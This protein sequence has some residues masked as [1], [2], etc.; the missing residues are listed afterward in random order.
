MKS[1]KLLA[2]LLTVTLV[3]SVMV[4]APALP[5]AVAAKET[6]RISPTDDTFISFESGKE[7]TA[8]GSQTTLELGY[9]QDNPLPLDAGYSGGS[10]RGELMYARDILMKFD[11]QDIEINSVSSAVLKLTLSENG[12]N[13]GSANN[14]ATAA[15]IEVFAADE[16]W[17]ENTV[18]RSSAPD[19]GN[20]AGLSAPLT[21]SNAKT[22]AVA[23]IDLTAYIRQNPQNIYSFRIKTSAS[24]FNFH[25]KESGTASARPVLEIETDGQLVSS[26][27]YSGSVLEDTYVEDS[28]NNRG[29]SFSD[30]GKIVIAAAD[31]TST[32]ALY[33]RNGY[34]KIELPT[35]G[36]STHYDSAKISLHA[37]SIDNDA[38]QTVSL[39]PVSSDW[40]GTDLTWDNRPEADGEA[41]ASAVISK[42][43]R[44]DSDALLLNSYVFDI[45]DYVNANPSVDGIYSFV[46]TSDTNISRFCT[47]EYIKDGATEEENQLYR[48]TVECI[49]REN[50][51]LTLHYT[52]AKFN[53]IAASK[54]FVLPVGNSFNPDD[55]P[56]ALGD[57][58]YFS[59]DLT[60][61][62][63][64]LP[65]T[66]NPGN[67]DVYL[68]YESK[69]I[70]GYEEINVTTVQYEKPVLPD[71]IEVSFSGGSNETFPVTW[72]EIAPENY[73]ASGEFTVMGTLQGIEAEGVSATVKV[74]G[75]TGVIIPTLSTAPGSRPALPETLDVNLDDETTHSMAVEWDEIA[76]E[77]YASVGS[78]VANGTIVLSGMRVQMTILVEEGRTDDRAAIADA[79]TQSTEPNDTHNTGELR[80]SGITGSNSANANSQRKTFLRFDG[81]NFG[82]VYHDPERNADID[83]IVNSTVRLYFNSIANSATVTYKIY[84]IIP[85]NDTWTEDSITWNNSEDVIDGAVYISSVSVK[86]SSFSASWVD[87]DVTSF[88]REHRDDEYLSFYVESD[89]CAAVLVSKDGDDDTLSPTLRTSGYI[90]DA[91]VTLRYMAEIGGK[92]TDIAEP[93]ALKGKLGY[94]YEYQSVIPNPIYY[95]DSDPD[96]IYYYDFVTQPAPP[97]ESES[98]PNL[99]LDSLT[100][101]YNEI[102]AEYT[103]REIT[104][105]ETVTAETFRGTKPELPASVTA[106][107]DNGT[108]VT[109][110]VTWN[111]DEVDF[112]DYSST[113]TFTLY[114]EVEYSDV[115]AEAEITVHE[116]YY[117]EPA[118]Q[119][120]NEFDIEASTAYRLTF[121]LI[122]TD[123][124]SEYLCGVSIVTAEGSVTAYD[125][126][127]EE[128][129]SYLASF[130]EGETVDVFFTSPE[131]GGSM[132]LVLPDCVNY[133]T[134]AKLYPVLGRGGDM[135]LHYMY[136]DE[137][138]YTAPINI[139]F[140]DTFALT[141][142]YF[143]ILNGAYTVT[144]IDSERSD[145]DNL[146]D[147]IVIDTDGLE[148]YLRCS[149][150][151]V[152]TMSTSVENVLDIAH[153]AYTRSTATL[154]NGTDADKTATVIV[155]KYSEDGKLES[156]EHE[157]LTIP[158]NSDSAVI[159]TINVPVTDGYTTILLWDEISGLNPF[160]AKVDSRNPTG[161][162][163]KPETGDLILIPTLSSSVSAS[164]EQTGNE[165]TNM[166]TRDL[167]T[168]W[169]AQAIDNEPVYA[170]IS[171]GG[172][173]DIHTIGLAFYNGS[174]RY[175]RFSVEASEDGSEWTE[176]ISPR[177]SSG[178]TSSV[179]YYTFAPVSARFIRLKGYGWKANV[180]TNEGLV[181][182]SDNWFSVTAF[183]AYGSLNDASGIVYSE[184]I[185]FE[186][187]AGKVLTDAISAGAG[188][189]GAAALN[190]MTYTNYTP[191]TGSALYADITATPDGVGFADGNTALRLYDNVDRNGDSETGAGS[192]G[193]FHK[194]DLSSEQYSIS[195]K[196]YIPN[197]IEGDTYNAQ[198]AGLS[199]SAGQVKG[200]ADTS[201]PVAL[202]LR[203]SP[204]GK[205]KMGF[206]IIRS[207]TYNEGSQENLL[208][209][210][211]PFKSNCVW[212]V[213]L[214]VNAAANTAVITVSDGS[215]TE[216]AF[217]SYGLYNEERTISQTWS[218]SSVN[219]IMF[220]TGAGG[221]CEMYVD[222][223]SVSCNSYNDEEEGTIVYEEDF[224]GFTNGEKIRAEKNGIS[225]ALIKETDQSYTASYGTMLDVDVNRSAMTDGNALHLY[226]Y[227][228]RENDSV[229][230]TGGVFAYIDLPEFSTETVTKIKFDMYAPIYGEYAG[231]ALAHG[232]N[233]GGDD[234]SNPLALQARFSPQT[235]GM[236]FNMNSSIQ[237]NKGS[238][239][240]LVGTGS[241]RLAYG[242][243]WNIE[244]SVNPLLGN[245]TVKATDGSLVSSK[246]VTIP[247]SGND[248]WKT[249]WSQT[250]IDTLIINTGA[251]TSAN[252][253]IDNITVIDTGLT[254]NSLA[255][256][257]G[258]IRLESV[259]GCDGTDGSGDDQ[260]YYVVHANAAGSALGV[261]ENQNPFYTRFVERKGLADPDSVSLEIMGKPGY[262]V[263]A[264]ANWNVSV[265]KYIDS[266]NFRRDATFN[267]VNSLSGY[268][269]K[270]DFSYQLYR[271]SK[272]Y[273]RL[274]GSYIT[275]CDASNIGKGTKE[276]CSFH[277]RSEATNYV[278]DSF[279]G[280]SISSQWY[281]GYPWYANYHNHSAV[282]RDQNIVVSGGRV[283]LRADK[284]NSN[285]WI[286]N[287]SGQTG[288]NDSINGG[289]WKKYSAWTGVI[290]INSKVFNKG[291][292]IEGSFKQPNSPR[293]YWTAFWLNGRDSWPPETDMFEY[294]SS[295][296]TSTWYTATHGGNEGAGWMTSSAVGNLRTQYHTFTIDW[297]YNYM[298]M[299][300]NGSLYFEAPDTSQQKNMY[301]ILNTGIGAWESEPNDTTVWGE[302]LECQWIRSYQYY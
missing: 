179:E 242:K 1:K 68:V 45:T 56:K 30:D 175:S 33:T 112:R 51:T 142:E 214:D 163:K 167:G 158:A 120:M 3:C 197:I 188:N 77:S 65:Y 6:L 106:Y 215:R 233:E 273:L 103:R 124:L 228:A 291:S 282:A 95:P 121:T 42:D 62:K 204:S 25:S 60:A 125:M 73:A 151:E 283:L 20:L 7:D 16:Q 267:K 255:A 166:L 298:K 299:Y 256:V 164:A 234:Q 155:A 198:W 236:Q 258:V 126:S 212:D 229:K 97:E 211:S 55:Y 241:N 150:S 190:E 257:N 147:S 75:I 183:E 89:L 21:S 146:T 134:D 238:Y 78:F 159:K 54:D 137:E 202:Q 187:M 247:T 290:S 107:L 200:G 44:N 193:A 58:Y 5:A 177:Y 186:G 160:L 12:K 22:D 224:S 252:I 157:K 71:E 131:Y 39:I 59:S 162:S 152:F 195:F 168:R 8:F 93:T 109:E 123:D 144:G 270:N 4:F 18:T 296:G 180:I 92:T 38:D 9:H 259:Y 132:T 289:T 156:V 209:S 66:V 35:N 262:Y 302:G 87:F 94:S 82:E 271:N 113:G 108:P 84:G 244:V 122:N 251:G 294:L 240:A 284:V 91:N 279:D 169:S 154:F 127:P 277:L 281:K 165:A 217:V 189:W 301:L 104:A 218:N 49:Y 41:V 17:S 203:L 116:A 74:L 153:D 174:S 111:W 266:D 246:T 31:G 264:D 227:V 184:N 102:V 48:P 140:G 47:N 172:L 231:F 139:A 143:T 138:I 69:S 86:Q 43:Y 245:M 286:K 213:R 80:I 53:D 15:V 114:G 207:I 24:G 148:A 128:F 29:V 70:S 222:D 98:D 67:N 275:V 13:M 129:L 278:S 191:S 263:V 79:Y 36:E 34:I 115:P 235:D 253:Y 250:P 221:K 135:T 249:D 276:A 196:W 52:D 76:P 226:D 237:Y 61:A 145:I 178:K 173:Y 297:G 11:L 223:F 280:N 19:T 295:K 23:E 50:A 161:E 149:Y 194:M 85:E 293:G 28:D 199:L 239:S 100:D 206:N 182:T 63:N 170:D 243:V 40:T 248:G 216:S 105:V 83:P 261:A 254:K 192:I 274:N 288:Y 141:E 37:Q 101:G 210:S 46:L 133:M 64:A 292:Y 136:N 88:V 72:S 225:S 265:Q 260:G 268:D 185:D 90:P 232:H 32:G 205:N 10:T 219:Y 300:V 181:E 171:L 118:Y 2:L 14:Q 117:G 26:E 96:G 27:F 201:H 269:S 176:I 287:S 99:Y 220:N 208:G 285:T 272:L 110:N 230:G 81:G 130:E 119:T 57:G